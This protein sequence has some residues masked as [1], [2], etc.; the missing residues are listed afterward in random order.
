MIY[1]MKSDLIASQIE[2]C[3]QWNTLSRGEENPFGR[4]I[5]NYNGYRALTW[6][7]RG[8]DVRN[9]ITAT[10]NCAEV[11]YVKNPRTMTELVSTKEFTNARDFLVKEFGEGVKMLD[12]RINGEIESEDAMF[13]RKLTHLFVE[14]KEHSPYDRVVALLQSIDQFH[15]NLCHYAKKDFTICEQG[16]RVFGEFVNCYVSAI[17]PVLKSECRSGSKH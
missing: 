4:F 17:V 9:E 5:F 13:A 8:N 16:A 2:T 1:R 11:L 7:C 14:S 3:E 12:L 15:T 6:L 10:K